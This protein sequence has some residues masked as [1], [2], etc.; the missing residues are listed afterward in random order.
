[1]REGALV[2]RYWVDRP[3]KEWNMLTARSTLARVWLG[4]RVTAQTERWVE[5]RAG[6]A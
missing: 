4:Q 1:M 6:G 2:W 3:P 5:S